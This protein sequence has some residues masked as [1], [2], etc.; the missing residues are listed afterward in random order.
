MSG[1]AAGAERIYLHEEGIT[2]NDLQADVER[3][4]GSFRDGRRFYL[5]I[6]NEFANSHYTTDFLGRLFEAEGGDH[7]DVR[8]AILGHI[9][10]GG[11]PSPFDRILATRLAAHCVDFLT[12]QLAE[13]QTES[14]FIGLVEGKVSIFPCKQMSDMVDWDY[15][16]PKEQWWL[17]LRSI[18]QALAQQ[19]HTRAG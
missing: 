6:R 16:R 2:L 14:A 4:L 8:Q 18:V 3:M 9:Q 5:T 19:P 10:Q 11:N 13:G 7:F 1:L 12:D 17:S 15:R